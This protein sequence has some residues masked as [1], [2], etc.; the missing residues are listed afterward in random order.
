MYKVKQIPEDFIVNEIS[1]TKVNKS[2][3]YTYFKLVKRNYT[4]ERAIQTIATD[5][6][7]PRKCFGYAGNKDKH[8]IT[9][10]L[11]SVLGQIKTRTLKD[12]VIDVLGYGNVPISLG[13]LEGNQFKIIVRNTKNSPT[14]TDFIVNYFD[15]QR[16]SKNNVHIGRAIIRKEF[17]KAA[18]AIDNNIVKKHLEEYPNDFIGAI[19]KLPHKTQT[20]YIN[21]YQSYLWNKVVELYIKRYFKDYFTVKYSLG[22]FVFLR[23][24]IKNFTI[25]LVS[26]DSEFRNP[27]VRA[28]YNTLLKEE[29]IVL[30]DF[31]IRKIN[32]LTPMGSERPLISEVKNLKISDLLKDELNEGM[33]KA[34]VEF[35]LQKGSYATIVI[36][37]IFY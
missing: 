11:C 25:P 8:A 3:R 37:K 12:I 23:Y 31:I 15:E 16:F 32:W 4:T 9:S 33:K 21:S 18:E 30:R 28:I 36:R 17:K 5:F 6:Q 7:I 22:E 1:A 20:I 26:F 19:K 10:Q 13:D 24:K 14:P 2:G 29:N 35:F 27:K 34:V